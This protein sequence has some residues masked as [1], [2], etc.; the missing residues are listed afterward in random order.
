MQFDAVTASNGSDAIRRLDQEKF[1]L[2]LQDL[3][4]PGI[5]GFTVLQ[6][7]NHVAPGIRKIVATGLVDPAVTKRVEDMG[8]V[9]MAKP[10]GMKALK[11]VI[12]G[13]SFNS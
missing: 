5:D 4:M 10:L 7:A 2:I 8:A 9:F 11:R 6:H 3:Q 13:M 1:D 12:D